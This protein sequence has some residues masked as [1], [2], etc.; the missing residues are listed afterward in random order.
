MP[1]GSA[2]DTCYVSNRYFPRKCMYKK[3]DI[4]NNP[5]ERNY[6]NAIQVENYLCNF[7]A[8]EK[9]CEK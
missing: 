8:F 3:L 6:A 1:T 5:G 9:F 7:K 2:H 4:I